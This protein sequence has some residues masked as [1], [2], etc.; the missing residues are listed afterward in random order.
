MAEVNEP[1]TFKDSLVEE[2]LDR[3]LSASVTFLVV[4]LVVYFTNIF[5]ERMHT[6]FFVLFVVLLPI[7]NVLRIVSLK[8]SNEGKIICAINPMMILE[9]NFYNYLRLNLYS[10]LIKKIE[11]RKSLKNLFQDI[12]V[13][14][15]V[16]NNKIEFSY[17]YNLIEEKYSSLL[18]NHILNYSQTRDSNEASL[19]SSAILKFTEKG[20][21]VNNLSEKVNKIFNIFYS[22]N[23]QKVI[24]TEKG[25]LIINYLINTIIN[26]KLKEKLK[27]QDQI[28]TSILNYKFNFLSPKNNFSELKMCKMISVNEIYDLKVT[29]VSKFNNFTIQYSEGNLL[30]NKAIVKEYIIDKKVSQD[31]KDKLWY[32]LEK[33]VRCL[34]LLSNYENSFSCILEYYGCIKTEETFSLVL[35]N[36]KNLTE[37]IQDQKENKKLNSF[38]FYHV[39]KSLIETFIFIVSKNIYHQNISPSCIY[40]DENLKI[41]VTDFIFSIIK[42]QNYLHKPELDKDYLSPEIIKNS[43]DIEYEKSDIYSLGL[44]LLQIVTLESIETVKSNKIEFIERLELDGLE[45]LGKMLR[46]MIDDDPEKRIGF[47]ELLLYFYYKPP[48]PL[49]NVS[50]DEDF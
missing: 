15:E 29:Q 28:L 35:N 24:S 13:K 26:R 20:M 16:F 47:N 50:D 18:S 1:S 33:E 27:T 23:K 37:Y 6:A 44:V 41:Y 17:I 36:R 7:M 48:E 8:L 30:G 21:D 4:S 40:I 38:Q 12:S 9:L 10:H 25:S 46:N 43:E 39:L 5:S 31:I 2:T 49:S 11:R 14:K 42:T 34:E 3:S 32:E 19:I 45:W 22:K